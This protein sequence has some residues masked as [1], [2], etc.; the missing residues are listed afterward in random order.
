MNYLIKI[1]PVILYIICTSLRKKDLYNL[2]NTCKYLRDKIIDSDIW[3]KYKFNPKLLTTDYFILKYKK[4]NVTYNIKDFYNTFN[5]ILSKNDQILNN[6]QKYM[7]KKYL[8]N[9][10]FIKLYHIYTNNNEIDQIKNLY[11]YLDKNQR[12][13]SDNINLNT[14]EKYVTAIKNINSYGNL[15][16]TN[17]TNILNNTYICTYKS[18]PILYI[19][20]GTNINHFIMYEKY[21]LKISRDKQSTYYY[22]STGFNKIILTMCKTFNF[23]KY[24]FTELFYNIIKNIFCHN[25]K[26]FSL[27]EILKYQL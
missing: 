13:K 15:H 11:V 17:L 12:K 14:F 20:D 21:M 6:Y 10:I 19:Y 22:R 18:D 9:K 27:N 25:E 23:D 4:I 16:L 7:I 26:L 3:I 24:I 1:P 5:I 2:M 8:D